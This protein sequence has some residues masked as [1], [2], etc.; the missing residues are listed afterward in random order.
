VTGSGRTAIV[1]APDRSATDLGA[2]A[3][4]G[5]AGGALRLA[6]DTAVPATPLPWG[7]LGVNVLGAF[8]LAVLAAWLWPV[9]PRAVRLALGPGLLGAFTTFSAVAVAVVTLPPLLAAGYLLAT[10]ALGLAA[11]FAGLAVGRALARRRRPAA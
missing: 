7:T 10:L 1:E 9:A 11:S 6:V 4:G 5:L 8:A 3:V 2:V